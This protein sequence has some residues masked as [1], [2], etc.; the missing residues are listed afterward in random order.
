MFFI[1]QQQFTAADITLCYNHVFLY[2]YS[3]SQDSNLSS[4]CWYA[5]RYH[6]SVPLGG[7]GGVEPNDRPTWSGHGGRT[8]RYAAAAQL[9]GRGTAQHRHL[10]VDAATA[11]RGSPAAEVPTRGCLLYV[12]QGL[13]SQVNAFATDL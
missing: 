12:V 4:R 1:F 3:R 10:A 11:A 8:G 13:S 2:F 9:R 5:Y 6:L 7:A